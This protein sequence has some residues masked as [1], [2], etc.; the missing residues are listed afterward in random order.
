MVTVGVTDLA[1]AGMAFPANLAGVVAVDA[2]TLTDA[3]VGHR[4]CE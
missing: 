4:R 1:D 2:T 3:T